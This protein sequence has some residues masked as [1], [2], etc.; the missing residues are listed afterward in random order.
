LQEKKLYAVI[1]PLEYFKNE[2]TLMENYS[3]VELNDPA[4]HILKA[5]ADRDYASLKVRSFL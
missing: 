3:N 2:G 4:V 1:A 5:S